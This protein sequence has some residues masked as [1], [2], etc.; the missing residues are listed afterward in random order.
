MLAHTNRK[1]WMSFSL[2]LREREPL[3]G[4]PV[5][6]SMPDDV[7]TYQLASIPNPLQNNAAGN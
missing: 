4:T 5:S 1:T 2:K 6:E 7:A 3:E